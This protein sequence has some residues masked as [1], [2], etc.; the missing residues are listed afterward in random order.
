MW[1]NHTNC[2]TFQDFRSDLGWA[3]IDNN[4]I[5]TDALTG[6]GRRKRRRVVDHVLAMAP[7]RPKKLSTE[8]GMLRTNINTSNISV[9]RL[10]A[11]TKYEHIV[12]VMLGSGCVNLILR[13]MLELATFNI[14]IVYLIQYFKKTW[15]SFLNDPLKL[16]ILLI[17]PLLFCATELKHVLGN[18]S[19]AF[20]LSKTYFYFS[21]L[22]NKMY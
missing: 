12:F 9:E 7:P 6:S 15:S 16:P 3:L 17:K 10:D 14:N 4:F 8:N 5:S 11:I 22:Q 20:D 13:S 18:L 2:I 19:T 1:K 21:Y